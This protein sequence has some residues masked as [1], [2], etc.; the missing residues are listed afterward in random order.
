MPET[1]PQ[2]TPPVLDQAWRDEAVYRAAVDLAN[3]VLAT[4]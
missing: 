2:D 4:K 3:E 1:T